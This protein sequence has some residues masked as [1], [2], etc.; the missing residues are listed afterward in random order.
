VN[1]GYIC[2]QSEGAPLQFRRVKIEPL[3][4]HP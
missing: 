4:N 1:D 2:L 3:P